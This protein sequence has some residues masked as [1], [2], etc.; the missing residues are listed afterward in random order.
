MG[1]WA[2][3]P[4][5]NDAAADWCGALDDAEPA[6]RVAM[7]E[8]ILREVVDERDYLDSWPAAKAVA[9]AAIVAGQ[10]PGGP[11]VDSA[12]AP[13][14]VTAGGRLDLPVHVPALAVQ[15]LDRVLAADSE[16]RELWDESDG[17]AALIAELAPIRAV[18]E[19]AVPT[20]P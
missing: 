8:R 20:R 10:L 12:Y 17:A 11:P 3:G 2:A 18:L 19:S 4:F 7:V 1:T 16:L 14:F 13:D 9:A 15:A 6:A 5:D